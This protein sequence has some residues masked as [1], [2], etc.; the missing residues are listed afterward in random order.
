VYLAGADALIYAHT[1][2]AVTPHNAKKFIATFRNNAANIF[3]VRNDGR[4][5]IGANRKGYLYVSGNAYVA[6]SLRTIHKG[7]KVNMMEEM[8]KVKEE[9][10]A[11]KA[12]LTEVKAQN[13]LLME[14]MAAMEASFARMQ[15]E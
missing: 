12:A 6:G 2:K 7:K 13:K 9:N 5:E 4:V 15:Q 14:R 3:R 10:T 11:M 1:K 8:D